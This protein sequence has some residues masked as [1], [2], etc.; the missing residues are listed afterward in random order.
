M[1]ICHIVPSLEERH[2]GPSRSSRCLAAALAELGHEVD[3]L[4]TQPGPEAPPERE[5]RLR[6]LRFHRDWPPALCPSAGLRHRL[7]GEPYDLIHHHALWLRTLH[8]AHHADAPLVISPRGMMSDWAWRHHRWKKWLAARLVHPGALGQ[9]AGWHATSRDEADE[10]RRRGFLQPVCVAANGVAAP[11]AEELTHAHETWTQRC[12]EVL[13]RPVAL[14]YS[15][16]HRK[17][18]LLELVDLW[19][20]LAPKDWLLLVVGIPEEFSVAQLQS[21]LTPESSAARIQVFDGRDLPP[22]YAVASLFLLPSHTENFGL[23]VA[24]AMAC[25]VPVLVTD[26][27]PWAE[28]SEHYAGWCVPWERYRDALRDALGESTDRLE[29]RGA[30]ARDWVL[31]RFS[32]EQAARPLSDFYQQLRRPAP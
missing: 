7:H 31:T 25:G 15:R 32:W 3:L 27:T 12:P 11:S 5:D 26:T 30:R 9:V 10:I 18:R 1:R 13:S 28:V 19:R 6:V 21:R 2:G 17:K 29:Q 23:V 24:E 14:F 20:D 16:F 8:Y 22:P 4:A